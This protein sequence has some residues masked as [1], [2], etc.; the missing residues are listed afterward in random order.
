MSFEDGYKAGTE[1]LAKAVQTAEL[2]GRLKERKRIIK[3]LDGYQ[4]KIRPKS[5]R[6]PEF[7]TAF[8]I[9]YKAAIQQIKDLH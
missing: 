4:N 8:K 1:G 5:S 6:I 7:A 9:G 3:I 2:L